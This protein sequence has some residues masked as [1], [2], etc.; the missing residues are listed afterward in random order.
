MK[1]AREFIFEPKATIKILVMV[2]LAFGVSFRVSAQR[3]CV[4][5]FKI[6]ARDEAGE[7]I[8]SGKLEVETLSSGGKLPGNVSHYVD[9]GGIYKVLGLM[10]T[11][12]KGNFLFR[13]S[14]PGFEVYERRF[15]FPLCEIQSYEL[16]LSAKSSSAKS[17][18]ERLLILHG[19]VFS[20]EMK[21]I[22]SAKVVAT[23]ANG[24][25]YRANS[26][27]YGYYELAVPKGVANIRVAVQ[28][29]PDVAFENYRIET[30]YSVLNVPV[31]LNCKQ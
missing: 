14:A 30:D 8:E 4:Y 18:F 29:S 11:T 13:I 26:N 25:A 27:A 10:G 15:N 2:I 19:K 20:E 31:C 22:T 5:G 12:L 23:F 21:P 6:Y 24:R 3:D 7:A 17:Q 16:R 28:G 9:P 1:Q